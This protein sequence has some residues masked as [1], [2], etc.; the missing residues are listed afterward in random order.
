MKKLFVIIVLGVTVLSGLLA[1]CNGVND[2]EVRGP[3]E[4]NEDSSEI[5]VEHWMEFTSITL[6]ASIGELA[7]TSDLI[8]HV[9]LV[10]NLGGFQYFADVEG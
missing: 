7:D 4:F 2:V 10:S 9:E 1:S 6:P 3:I 8:V 5:N